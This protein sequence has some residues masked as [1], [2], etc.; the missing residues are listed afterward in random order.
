LLYFT[1]RLYGAFFLVHIL[2]LTALLN[3]TLPKVG[4]RAALLRLMILALSR[5]LH[6]LK[7]IGAL[8]A[9]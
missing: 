8:I 5:V 7:K 6:T 1:P 3:S 4:V 2:P 9:K